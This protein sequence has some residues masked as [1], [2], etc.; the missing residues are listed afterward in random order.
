M[1]RHFYNEVMLVVHNSRANIPMKL[2]ARDDLLSKR[3]NSFDPCLIMGYKTIFKIFIAAVLL[4][5]IDDNRKFL[6]C[7]KSS[8]SNE[9]RCN[10]SYRRHQCLQETK[11]R[12]NSYV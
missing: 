6:F 7:R 8:Q 11:T 1:L 9:T 3:Q 2:I 4:V 10:S 5:D 12:I